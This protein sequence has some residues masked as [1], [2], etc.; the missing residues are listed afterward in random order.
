MKKTLLVTAALCIA[1]MAAGCSKTEESSYATTM[2]TTAETAASETEISDETEGTETPAS[3]HDVVVEDQSVT[4][5]SD[6]TGDYS[7]TIPKLIVDGQEAESINYELKSTLTE[8][9]SMEKDANS[10]YVTGYEMRYA[11]GV[12]DNIVSIVVIAGYIGDDGAD[13]AVFNYDLDNLTALSGD[14][15]VERLD[16][17]VDEFFDSVANVYRTYWENEPW[18]GEA[19]NDML[20]RSISVIDFEHVKPF[21]TPSGHTGFAG[22]IYTPSQSAEGYA[23]FDMDDCVR[24]G[25]AG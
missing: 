16:M 24:E 18:L 11:W 2:D 19:Y 6:E 15:V 7:S 14:E 5:L 25:F 9:Y 8:K 1:V 10:G 21:I 20:D 13:Y 22:Y 23:C 17:S 4:T 3:Q 12:K